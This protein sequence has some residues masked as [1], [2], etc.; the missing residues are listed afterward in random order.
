MNAIKEHLENMK[1]EQD[2]LIDKMLAAREA[3]NK[4]IQSLGIAQ[5][6]VSPMMTLCS[7]C[8]FL[9]WIDK[10]DSNSL[11]SKYYSCNESFDREE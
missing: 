1:M 5:A 7:C 10:E 2:S 6:Y 3:R 4:A 11:G 9:G 8:S